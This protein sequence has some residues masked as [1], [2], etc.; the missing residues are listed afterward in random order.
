MSTRIFSSGGEWL[1]LKIY[2]GVKTADII[3]QETITHLVS[4]LKKE[5]SLK[6]GFLSVTATQTLILDYGFNF[7]IY[8]MMPKF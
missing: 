3:L 2:C 6:S 1:Y 8:R 7:R 4:Q 5:N